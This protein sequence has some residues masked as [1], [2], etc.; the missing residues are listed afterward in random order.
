M[1]GIHKLE[2]KYA[3]KAN[4]M[5][6]DVCRLFDKENIPYS[7]EAGTLLGVIREDR[8]LPWDSDLD[9]VS[10]SD[11]TSKIVKLK[12]K[13]WFKLGYRMKI[14]YQHND[15]PKP[16]KKGDIRV[17]KIQVR[18][19]YFFKAYNLMDIFIVKKKDDNYYWFEGTKP[20]VLK[21]VPASFYDN[22]TRIEYNKN[23]F[24]VV[25]DYENYLEYRYGNWKVPHKEYHHMKDDNA[26][27]KKAS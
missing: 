20:T 4:K 3:H 9:I 2:G 12:R 25:K 14:R 5:L 15:V 23:K 22:L 10:F 13:I 24:T 21:T 27:V 1:A 18:R 11:Y 16:F 7:L 26:L 8:L 17:I 19:F 6:K